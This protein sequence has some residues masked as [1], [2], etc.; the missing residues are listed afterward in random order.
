MLHALG[1]PGKGRGLTLA[2]TYKRGPQV[3]VGKG[4]DGVEEAGSRLQLL[5]PSSH[6]SSN[7]VH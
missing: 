2:G 6:E 5:V 1:L 4:D 3:N 7:A